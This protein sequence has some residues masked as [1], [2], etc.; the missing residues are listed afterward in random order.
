MAREIP[1]GEYGTREFEPTLSLKPR[2]EAIAANLTEFLKKNDR[3]G[4]PIIFCV[5]QE[6][7]EDMRAALNNL[8]ADLAQRQPNY[9]RSHSGR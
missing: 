2:T 8:N 1:D 4:K 7:A 3:W 5:D 6:H 9:C